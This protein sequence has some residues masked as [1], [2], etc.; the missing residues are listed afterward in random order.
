MAPTVKD[1]EAKRL[2]IADLLRA[3]VPQQKICEI[4]GVSP[5]TVLRTKKK[6]EA[7][8]DLKHKDHG[9]SK[10]KK[11]TPEFLEDM[12]SKFKA[13]NRTSVREMAKLKNVCP[14][15]ISKGLKQ[16]GMVSK[17]M[18]NMPLLTEAQKLVRF[19]RSTKLIS[20]LKKLPKSTV[21]IFS[22]KKISQWIRPT[23]D[24]TIV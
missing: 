13:K 19:T 23:T 20:C 2:R 3:Q 7:G 11:L 9:P 15:T 16:L 24:V 10:L 6:L 5:S 17:A 22:D 21:R 4:V 8:D 18:P 12:K 1:Q 14:A